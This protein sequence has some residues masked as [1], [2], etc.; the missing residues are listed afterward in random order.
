[1]L[2]QRSRAI[3]S[4]LVVFLA[5]SGLVVAALLAD[6]RTASESETND[7]GA[8]LLNRSQSSIGHVNRVVGE[9][10]NAVGPFSGQFDV[11]QAESVVVVHNKGAGQAVLLDTNLATPGSP[12]SV[13]ETTTVAAGPGVVV[14]HDRS[15][16]AVWRFRQEEFAAV[17]TL[18]SIAPHLEGGVDARPAVGRDGTVALADPANGSVQFLGLD[19]AASG[20]TDDS[21]SG[22]EVVDFTLVGS[23]GVVALTDQRLVIVEDGKSRVV[24]TG[25]DML[26]LQQSSPEAAEVVGVSAAGEVVHITL[27]TGAVAATEELAGAVPLKP[28]VY[29]GCVWAVTVEPTPVLYHCGRTSPLTGA[30]SQLKLTL[31]ERCRPGR[32]LVC[33]RGQH[34]QRHQRLDCRSRTE[35]ERRRQ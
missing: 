17:E 19:G 33:P 32:H 13:S 28:I 16:G 18:A 3:V 12:V 7:G 30:S 35:R 26:V 10:S 1:L 22:A 34:S 6:G 21:W 9:I 31:G 29:D 27:A 4:G 5:F 24:D 14:L 20:V 11:S 15:L 2:K 23:M 25:I 8:W